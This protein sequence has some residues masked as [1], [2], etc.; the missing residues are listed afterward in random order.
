M[1]R[2]FLAIVAV[3]SFAFAA[4]AHSTLESSVP[5]DGSSVTEAKFVHLTFT[6]AVRLATLKVIGSAGEKALAVDRSA[7]AGRTFSADLPALNPGKYEV[8]WTASARDG[9]IM[10]GSFSFTLTAS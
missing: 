3:L 5:A 1:L 2:T 7:P 8:K 10:T 9:H 6:K 4:E